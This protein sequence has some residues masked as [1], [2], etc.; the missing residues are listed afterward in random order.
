MKKILLAH[1]KKPPYETRIFDKIAKSL[2]DSG[3]FEI[4]ILGNSILSDSIILSEQNI[5]MYPVFQSRAHSSQISTDL[6]R[7]QTFLYSERPDVVIVCSP[8]LLALAVLYSLIEKKSVVLDLQENYPFNY[9]YQSVYK[10]PV[11][12]LLRL[13]SSLYLSVLIPLVQ[14]VWLAE[15]I[16][17]IQLKLSQATVIENKVPSFWQITGSAPSFHNSDYLL[18]SGYISE[19]SGALM[20]IDFFAAFRS[21]FPK[22]EL[23]ISGYC[24]SERLKAEIKKRS[25]ANLGIRWIG[26]DTW[27][28]SYSILNILASARAV[29]MPYNET[30]ANLGKV[31]TKLYEAASLQIPVIFP[32]NSQFISTGSKLRVPVIEADFLNPEAND[33]QRINSKIILAHKKKSF[34]IGSAHEFESEK[35]VSEINDLISLS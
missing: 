18:F 2:S 22:L 10:W 19:E 20:A 21:V 27:V 6:L 28:L 7:F 17:S 1:L 15:G 31:P 3:K 26:L 35:I 25:E 14:K 24:P 23:I 30:P 11:N 4:T 9:Y 29:L 33:F 32:F 8:E 12:K 34:P 16:Y 5:R 13:A